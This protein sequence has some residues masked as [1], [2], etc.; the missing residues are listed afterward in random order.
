MHDINILLF[1]SHSIFT[2]GLTVFVCNG[3]NVFIMFIMAEILSL[4]GILN[5][6][7]YSHLFYSAN[8]QSLPL[9]LYSLG[10]AEAAIGLTLIISFV[11]LQ[12]TVSL[13]K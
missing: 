7:T 11:K 12:G 4:S 1:L 9:I 2:L 6:I 8:I 10:A 13:L 3:D 5:F